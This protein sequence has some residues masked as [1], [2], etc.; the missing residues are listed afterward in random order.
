MFIAALL[1]MTKV[2]K[3]PKSMNKETMV[4]PY[5]GMTFGNTKE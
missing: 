2:W 5:S 4:Y 3:Q 1:T